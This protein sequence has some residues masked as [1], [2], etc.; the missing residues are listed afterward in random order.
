MVTAIGGGI[1]HRKGV[2]DN[3]PETGRFVGGSSELTDKQRNFVTKYVA[4]GGDS[5]E[6]ARDAGYA[7]PPQDSWRLMRNPAVSAQIRV[8]MSAKIE[9]GA[10]KG[11]RFMEDAVDDPVM[12][13]PVRFQAAKFLVEA[14]GYGLAAQALQAKVGGEGEK[15][16]SEMTMGELEDHVKRQGAAFDAMKRAKLEMVEVESVTEQTSDTP[17]AS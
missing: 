2:T 14:A 8:A 13:A 12:P 3:D 16:L 11:L 17:V 4:N 5:L 7:F 1:A 6:A 15:L 9:R 10:A